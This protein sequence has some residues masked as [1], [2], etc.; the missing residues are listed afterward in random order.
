MRLPF[1]P[2]IMY[3]ASRAVHTDVVVEPEP[4]ARFQASRSDDLN[5][6]IRCNRN[7]CVLSLSSFLLSS[8]PR[9]FSSSGNTRFLKL[10]EQA[11]AKEERFLFD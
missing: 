3:H 10:S 1:P 5:I 4:P 2:L 11:Q 8:H 7:V 6:L 9:P